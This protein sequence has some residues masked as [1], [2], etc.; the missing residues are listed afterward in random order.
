MSPFFG[1]KHNAEDVALLDNDEYVVDK[2]ISH[3]GN[4][5]QRTSLD[6][7]HTPP[8]L[9]H[10]NPGNLFFT[11]KL[12]MTTYGPSVALVVGRDA[13]RGRGVV[14]LVTGC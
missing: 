4:F 9:T 3:R 8:N 5:R 2:I 14:G 13:E 12:S 1:T 6:G 7:A 11:S 10:G